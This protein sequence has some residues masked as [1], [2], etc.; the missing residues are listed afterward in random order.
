MSICEPNDDISWIN[1][2]RGVSQFLLTTDRDILITIVGELHEQDFDCEMNGVSLSMFEYCN[3]RVD[4]NPLCEVF[5]EYPPEFKDHDRIGSKIIRD[6]FTSGPNKVQEV[7]SGIDIRRD[8]IGG[9]NHEILYHRE[10]QIPN[11]LEEIKKKYID[12]FSVKNLEEKCGKP[13]PQLSKH[14][15]DMLNTKFSNISRVYQADKNEGIM[16]LKWAWAMVTDYYI[17]NRILSD[18]DTK[19]YIVIIGKNHLINLTETLNNMDGCKSITKITNNN[20]TNC[21]AGHKMKRIC[22]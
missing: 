9:E 19:E 11:S 13:E 12:P 4:A 1:S 17:L 8:F 5:L 18:K 6:V 7:T 10:N 14:Y 2:A 22:I 21:V 16:S 15:T 3:T 20:E